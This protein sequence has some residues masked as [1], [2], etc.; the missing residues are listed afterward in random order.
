MFMLLLACSSI[1]L[2]DSTPSFSDMTCSGTGGGTCT[3]NDGYCFYTC[4][5]GNAPF[6][7]FGPVSDGSQC[8]SDPASRRTPIN[9]TSVNM[10]VLPTR[11]KPR[12]PQGTFVQNTGS[13]LPKGHCIVSCDRSHLDYESCSYNDAPG[14]LLN[15]KIGACMA[16]MGAALLWLG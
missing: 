10:G 5:H 13:T 4:T 1:V 3:A 14:A 16:L 8:H 9:E 7:T 15:S 2:A 12:V 6:F 11:V